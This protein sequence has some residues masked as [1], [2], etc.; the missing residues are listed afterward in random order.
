MDTNRRTNADRLRKEK[1]PKKS[2]GQCFLIDPGTARRIVQEA[3]IAPEDVVLEIGPGRGALTG[4]LLE[5]GARVIG[6]E[7][8]QA[9]CGEL[10]DQFGREERFV[11][12]VGDILKLDWS[13]LGNISRLCFQGDAIVPADGN[14][15]V[16]A[17]LPY[18]IT[19]PVL[20]KLLDHGNAIE[21]ALLMVQAEV[22]KR[23]VAQPG[24]KDRGILSVMVQWKSHPKLLFHVHRSCFR[25]SPRVDS[26]VI[27]LHFG[28]TPKSFPEDERIFTGIVRT[29][30]GQRRKMLRNALSPFGEP[31][32]EAARRAGIDLTR[33][34]ETLSVEEFVRLSD[35][36]ASSHTLASQAQCPVR[37]CNT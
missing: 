4:H 32:S 3:E 37:K 6:V 16:V 5:Q 12:V 34:A 27:R 2:L 26:C 11:L 28:A 22:G 15:K 8:D 19:S 10:K 24:G 20:F 14:L 7:I 1:R 23:I 30:F 17:N 9:L 21:R 33:R 35:A 36:F 31:L 13:E 18:H 29:A 25:P